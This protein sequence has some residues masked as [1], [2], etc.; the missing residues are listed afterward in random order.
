M[1]EDDEPLCE[2]NAYTKAMQYWDLLVDSNKV[3]NSLR[4]EIKRLNE[5]IREG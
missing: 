1:T 2:A 4:A 3:I 5:I